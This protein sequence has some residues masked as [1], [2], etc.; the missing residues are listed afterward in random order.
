MYIILKEPKMIKTRDSL[1]LMGYAQPIKYIG[2][3]MINGQTKII[4]YNPNFKYCF[5][6]NQ[7]EY[8]SIIFDSEP[9]VVDKFP[10]YPPRQELRVDTLKD[11]IKVFK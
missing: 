11:F 10:Y 8:K 3:A 7:D 5:L 4:G 6:L 1:K 2:F 9:K